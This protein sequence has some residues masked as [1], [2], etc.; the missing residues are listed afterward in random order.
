[1]AK[2]IGVGGVFFK[3]AN[4]PEVRAWYSKVLGVEI[5][6]YGAMFPPLPYGVT[7]FN[8]FKA[9]TSYFAPSTAPVM[10]NLMVDDMAGVLARVKAAGVPVLKQEDGAYGRFAQI[11]DPTGLKLELWEPSAES[12]AKGRG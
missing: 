2:V 1:M 6:D 7:V 10:L 3:A 9:S 12:K 8:A 11:M 4:A 5:G